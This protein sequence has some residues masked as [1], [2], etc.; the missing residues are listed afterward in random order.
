VKAAVSKSHSLQLQQGREALRKNAW[1][2]AYAR[3]SA[4]DRKAPLDAQDLM[5]FSMAAL[6]SGKDE[7]SFRLLERAHQGFLK[8]G[9][10][11]QA[12][13]C[14]VWL[15]HTSQYRGD[16]AQASGWIARAER[17]LAGEKQ[18]VEQGYLLLPQGLRAVMQGEVDK[19]HEI[20]AQAAAIGQKYGEGDLLAMALHGQG[21]AAIRRGEITQGV[22]LLDE[23]MVAVRA[24][25]LTPIISGIVYCGVI[26]SCRETFDVQSAQEWTAA[27][28]DWCAA[29]P[30]MVPYH[31]VCMLHRAEILQ[32]H[33]EW[34]DA[35]MEARRACEQ[36]STPPPKPILG[37]ALYRLAELHRVRG[38]LAEAEA[39]YLQ[40][41]QWERA[42]E[43]G[44]AQLQ[45]AQGQR[46]AALAAIKRIAGEVKTG[47]G[48]V[49]VL[50]AYAEIALA[51]GDF[52][53]AREAADELATIAAKH[54]AP[55]LLARSG[56][57]NGAV[58]L[59]EGKPKAALTGLRNS[60]RIWL[61]LEAPHEVARTRVLIARACREL[62]D[63]AAAE[64]EFVAAREVFEQLGAAA[65]LMQLEQTVG[66][67][68][69]P[70]NPLSD[71][72]IGVLR[73]V[74][75]GMTNRKIAGKLGISEKTVARHVSN[76]FTKLDLNS[77]AAAT[78]YAYQNG[79]VG[80]A[81]T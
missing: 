57:A 49:R 13:R 36:M 8:E 22:A 52:A 66:K 69:S 60:W 25:E 71:R 3:L 70:E 35:L 27:L 12:I 74:A 59:A 32:L 31:G 43:P 61:E 38:E 14:A 45:L 6:L 17:M 7:E 72:E 19:A 80:A 40:A 75:S 81:A 58:L 5:G 20:F 42:P 2:T 9:D 50:D 78:A 48:R 53:A 67:A 54:G 77:R 34:P 23:A 28:N 63:T 55:M 21:R 76:I 18:C 1:A 15:G 64:Q 16:F 30:E 10:T 68:S 29:Q 11:L 44:I 33:G 51:A 24:G 56:R 62:G 4:A 47:E 39:A 73:L 26:D 79:L 46:K 41:K 65:D 37:A